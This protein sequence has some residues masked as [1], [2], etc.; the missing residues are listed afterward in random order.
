MQNYFTFFSTSSFLSR[1]YSRLSKF[2]TGLKN[3]ND[4]R[5]Q[6]AWFKCDSIFAANQRYLCCK[7]LIRKKHF[8]KI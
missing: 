4:T 8:K 3:L 6:K 7:P 1:V 5:L 2:E